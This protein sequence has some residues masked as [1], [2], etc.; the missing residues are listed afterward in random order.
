MDVTGT[1]KPGTSECGKIK[2]LNGAWSAL[3][4]PLSTGVQVKSTY[5]GQVTITVMCP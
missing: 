5:T 3:S 2:T 1:I 4:T